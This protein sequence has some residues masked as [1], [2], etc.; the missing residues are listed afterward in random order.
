MSSAVSLILAV[1]YFLSLQL[2]CFVYCVARDAVECR[3]GLKAGVGGKAGGH[4]VG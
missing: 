1:R 2:L 4:K 3:L